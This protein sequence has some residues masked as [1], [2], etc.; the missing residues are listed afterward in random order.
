M[1][2]ETKTV[3]HNTLEVQR[4]AFDQTKT[5]K[6]NTLEVQHNTFDQTKM[7][8]PITLKVQRNAF[9]QTK[10]MKSNTLEIQCKNTFDQKINGTQIKTTCNQKFPQRKPTEPVPFEDKL[11]RRQQI[12]TVKPDHIDS[13]H[14][15]VNI[16]SNS[17]AMVLNIPVMDDK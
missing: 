1:K 3:K 7:V 5:V 6:P 16:R 2:I 13:Q 12:F 10:T 17:P 11:R 15:D 14:K 8:K 9:D 4:N